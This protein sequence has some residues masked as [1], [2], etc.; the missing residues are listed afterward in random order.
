MNTYLHAL[1]KD[2]APD[3][4][5]WRKKYHVVRFVVVSVL[6]H[7]KV[8][9]DSLFIHIQRRIQ[10]PVNHLRWSFL[11]GNSKQ[12]KTVNYFF[13]KAPSQIFVWIRNTLPIWMY[14]VSFRSVSSAA[15]HVNVICVVVCQKIVQHK[16]LTF[17]VFQ[18]K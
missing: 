11:Y 17:F 4:N 2:F 18:Y 5:V 7:K 14:L 6:Y 15:I 1:A 12:L 8:L 10:N 13:K 16:L 9:L 3:A